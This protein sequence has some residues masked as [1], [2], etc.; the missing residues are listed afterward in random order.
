MS[1]WDSVKETLDREAAEN[2][3]ERRQAW[4][5]RV[6]QRALALGTEGTGSET[7]QV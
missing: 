5:A 3:R 2:R 1:Y 4:E 7:R 6:R